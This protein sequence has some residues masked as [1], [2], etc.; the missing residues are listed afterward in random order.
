MSLTQKLINDGNAAVD[1]MLA[2]IM[3][4]HP[5]HLWRPDN[6]PRAVVAKHGPRTGKVALVIGGGSG[7]EPTSSAM[8]ARAWRMPLRSAMSSP[9]RLRSPRSTRRWP[10]A[11]APASC[12]CMATM[13]AT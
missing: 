6:A 12:S 3:A 10:R 11:A 9:R 4:A 13:P 8:S 1:E 7:H 5:E 2:G